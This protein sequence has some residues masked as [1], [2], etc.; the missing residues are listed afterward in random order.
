[1]IAA[2]CL[3]FFGA[4]LALLG[5]KCTKIGGSDNTKSRLT[6]LSGFHFLLS[7]I[8][9]MTACSIYARRITTDFFDPLFV[10]QKFEL[11]AALFVGWV[12]SVLCILGG[13]VFCLSASE[14]FSLKGK[15]RYTGAPSFGTKHSQHNRTAN[16]LQTEPREPRRP[17]QRNAY[18]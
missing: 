18:V 14:S 17:L 13:L 12:G 8:C 3:G 7:G 16:S 9:C 10:K 2:V 15:Y 1:M 4:T 11:G 5:M 6:V